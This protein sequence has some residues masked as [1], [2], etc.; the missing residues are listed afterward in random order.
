M[1]P[2]DIHL[3]RLRT[4]VGEVQSQEVPSTG[5]VIRVPSVALPVGWNKQV[6]RVSFV[7][8]Q[9]Y[10]FAKPDCFWTDN[11]LRLANGNMPQNA[12]L[13]NPI[14]GVPDSL[15]WFSWHVDPWNPNRD[16]L[17][18]WFALIKQRLSK[19]Q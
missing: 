13:N 10:P 4:R 3:E 8:P 16:D 18:T 11:D 9:G 1:G 6:I 7:A 12:Q 19:P 5:W 2:I 15:L 17:L 14:P